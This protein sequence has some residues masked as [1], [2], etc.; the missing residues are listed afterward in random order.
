M[1]GYIYKIVNNLNN[2][3]YIG[4]TTN[5]D[6]RWLCHKYNAFNRKSSQPLYKA[7]RKYGIDNFSIYIIDSADI[8]DDLNY[9]E[10]YWIDYYKSNKSRNGYNR[11]KGGDG[12]DTWSSRSDDE[13]MKTSRLLSSK[14]SG[15]NNGSWGKH[16]WTNGVDQAYLVTCPEGWHS[17]NSDTVR[18]NHSKSQKGK[19]RSE[20]S[21]ERY[22]LS[23][24]GD[25]NPSKKKIGMRRF[26]NLNTN[27]LKFMFPDDASDGWMWITD[28]NRLIKK[29]GDVNE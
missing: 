17:G 12:G 1:Y 27:E 7:I 18:N 16:W 4:K 15:K 26:I 14:L 24:L 19:R 6:R 9:K 13:K 2:K 10:I 3:I 29:G 20:E 28:Y 11:T 23:K 22:R 25:K 8:K 21:K 5:V